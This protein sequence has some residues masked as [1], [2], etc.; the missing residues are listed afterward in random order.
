MRIK[1]IPVPT[2]PQTDTC[3]RVLISHADRMWIAERENAERFA[4]RVRMVVPLATTVLGILLA[5]TTQALV[6]DRF[7]RVATGEQVRWI[8]LVTVLISVLYLSRCIVALLFAVKG[9]TGGMK[10][11]MSL[12]FFGLSVVAIPSEMLLWQGPEMLIVWSGSCIAVWRRRGPQPRPF[13]RLVK[14]IRQFRERRKHHLES[15]A[16]QLLELSPSVRMASQVLPEP[17]FSVY[18]CTFDAALKLRAANHQERQRVRTA[19]VDLAK[20]LVF[21]VCAVIIYVVVLGWP[22]VPTGFWLK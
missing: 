1:R 17:Y 19:E 14:R 5:G 20:G 15:F 8:F 18:M 12:L 16:S 2:P 11:Q 7:R 6:A 21:A 10:S 9:P 13:W 3:D 4:A 22:T